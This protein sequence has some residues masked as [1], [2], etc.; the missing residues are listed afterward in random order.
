MKA[1]MWSRRLNFGSFI[2]LCSLLD[3]FPGAAQPAAPAQETDADQG[4]DVRA[5]LA[6]ARE[7]CAACHSI[8]P[9]RR[10]SPNDKAPAFQVL[11]DMP[12]MTGA[13]VTIWLRTSHPTMPNLQLSSAETQNIVA[14]IHSLRRRRE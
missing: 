14:Y 7:V 2:L 6:L 11:A 13:A 10:L 1:A 12:S 8:E 4:G 3:A 5:G 9:G